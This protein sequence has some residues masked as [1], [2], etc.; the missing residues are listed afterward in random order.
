MRHLD[1]HAI[2]LLIE[3]AGLVVEGTVE[4]RAAR[5]AEVEQW[6]TIAYDRAT[7]A[8]RTAFVELVKAGGG[9]WP[10]SAV[11]PIP[12]ELSE[13]SDDLA[14]AIHRAPPAVVLVVLESTSEPEFIDPD[15]WL[16]DGDEWIPLR[17][18]LLSWAPETMERY[19]STGAW[20]PPIIKTD[21][22]EP[23]TSEPAPGSGSSGEG[24]KGGQRPGGIV[25]PTQPGSAPVPSVWRSWQLWTAV[26]VAA[27]ATYG[28]TRI[29]RG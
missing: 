11:T 25:P 12:V 15:N 24:I 5:S 20:S 1:R 9:E 10:W 29:R 6:L 22:S 4:A 8:G 7:Q 14:R 13:L 17:D 16:G 28:L 19:M 27:A 18:A 3:Y 26:G 21:A 23:H 2:A